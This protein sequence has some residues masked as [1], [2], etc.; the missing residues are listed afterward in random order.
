MFKIYASLFAYAKI[1][2]YRVY[3]FFGYAVARYFPKQVK[4][5]LY[6]YSAK[7]SAVAINK[8]LLCTY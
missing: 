7:V 8:S 1:T 3:Y 4:G 6:M 2:E 5:V